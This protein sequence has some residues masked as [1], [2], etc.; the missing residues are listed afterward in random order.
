MS[1]QH[2]DRL[3]ENRQPR[4]RARK[5]GTLLSAVMRGQQQAAVRRRRL[6]GAI[7]AVTDDEFR[8]RCTI[9]PVRNG[10]LT[11]LVDDARWVPLLRERW[12]LV[13]YDRLQ[14]GG[15]GTGVRRVV[16]RSRADGLWFGAQ[17]GGD[18][19][20][21]AAGGRAAGRRVQRKRPPVANR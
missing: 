18:R 2:L 12:L 19:R 14:A 3:V 1:D 15:C 4:V 9:G 20:G 8:S 5:L 10:V 6:Q 11:I 13:L 21:P 17:E 7:E 16:F